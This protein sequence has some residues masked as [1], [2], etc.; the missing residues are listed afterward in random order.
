MSRRLA[1]DQH[2]LPLIQE[3]TRLYNLAKV[4]VALRHNLEDLRNFYESALSIPNLP[5]IPCFSHIP[6]FFLTNEGRGPVKFE[7][8]QGSKPFEISAHV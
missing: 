7:C 8:I 1:L 6:I 4:F 5:R 2:A 3:D